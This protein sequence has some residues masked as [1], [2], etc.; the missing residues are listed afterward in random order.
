M[1]KCRKCTYYCLMKMVT[2]EQSLRYC[3]DIPCD[4]CSELKKEHNEFTPATKEITN[5][6]WSNLGK[7]NP[8]RAQRVYVRGFR[9]DCSME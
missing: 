3:G 9:K 2:S 4:R 7:T 1:S 8:E 6:Q 5:E